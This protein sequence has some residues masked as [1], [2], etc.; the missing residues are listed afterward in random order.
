[1]R[2]APLSAGRSPIGRSLH[3]RA[4]VGDLIG[5]ERP[6]MRRLLLGTDGPRSMSNIAQIV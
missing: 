2:L 5:W 1:M 4:N 3:R 6:P